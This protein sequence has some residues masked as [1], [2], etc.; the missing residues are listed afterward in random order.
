MV[1]GAVLGDRRESDHAVAILQK[2]GD[3]CVQHDLHRIVILGDLL[4]EEVEVALA[5]EAVVGGRPMG[6][7]IPHDADAGLPGEAV[8]VEE[9]V[10]GGD[11]LGEIEASVVAV[12]AVEQTLLQ[13]HE[14]LAIEKRGVAGGLPCRIALLDLGQFLWRDLGG[15]G[16]GQIGF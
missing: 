2:G 11:A 3:G 12:S 16:V 14:L 6:P 7:R 5:A 1:G 4:V 10:E 13:G 8:L 9:G 15:D